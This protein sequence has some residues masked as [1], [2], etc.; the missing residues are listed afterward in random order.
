MD[1]KYL[2][3]LAIFLAG[4]VASSKVRQLPLGNKLPVI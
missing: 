4:V 1:K 2:I 3:Y